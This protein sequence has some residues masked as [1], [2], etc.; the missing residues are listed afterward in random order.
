[1][2]LPAFYII[3]PWIA[4]VSLMHIFPAEAETGHQHQDIDG[5]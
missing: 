2:S 4:M 5:Q 3:M 1:M